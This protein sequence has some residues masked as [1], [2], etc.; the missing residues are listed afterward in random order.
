MAKFID[1]L[2]QSEWDKNRVNKLY[3]I[4]PEIT[5]K[6]TVPQ[7]RRDEVVMNRV[8]IGHTR[9]THKHILEREEL[10]ICT[11]CRTAKTIHHILICL[12]F[13]RQ[14]DY[15]EISNQ[16]PFEVLRTDPQRVMKYLK[17]IEL[18]NVI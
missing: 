11:N 4:L 14:R 13:I 5:M 15:I 17:E 10:P 18:Y 2:W 8:R 16:D 12:V 6:P 7:K 1:D 9:L 3:P